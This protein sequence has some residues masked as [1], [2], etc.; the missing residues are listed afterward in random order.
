MSL[1]RGAEGKATAV[2]G[3]G[4]LERM[5]DTVF[6]LSRSNVNHDGRSYVLTCTAAGTGCL[7]ERRISNRSSGSSVRFPKGW[8]ERDAS[9]FHWAAA[10]AIMVG[11]AYPECQKDIPP[12][13]GWCVSLFM[14]RRFGKCGVWP[15]LGLMMKGRFPLFVFL[16]ANA[17]LDKS[18]RD[19]FHVSWRTSVQ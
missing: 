6:D 4:L 2:I 9:W 5:K 12:S 14:G 1:A 3:T 8:G 7:I 13:L 15:C 19:G 17:G 11:Q 16:Y 10:A 18:A